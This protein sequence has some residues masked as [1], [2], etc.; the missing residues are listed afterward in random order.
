MWPQPNLL[1]MWLLCCN[2]MCS[3]PQISLLLG[4]PPKPK[5]WNLISIVISGWRPDF[6][7]VLIGAVACQSAGSEFHTHQIYLR[8]VGGGLL[9]SHVHGYTGTERIHQGETRDRGRRT[10]WKQE[11]MLLLTVYCSVFRS[12]QWGCRV[13]CCLFL[14][15]SIICPISDTSRPPTP[16]LGS[17]AT[18]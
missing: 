17:L 12:H 4:E 6:I 13:C 15:N 18:G 9:E 3:H 7:S 1:K 16:A 11:G 10:D 8:L 14:P 2:L 5:T